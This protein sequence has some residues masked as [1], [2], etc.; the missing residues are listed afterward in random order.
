MRI[1]SAL[2][3]GCNMA[4]KKAL[5]AGNLEA[6]GAARLA[7]LLIKISKGRTVARRLLRLELAGLEGK[8]ALARE[9]RQRMATIRRSGAVLDSQ[10]HRDLL[11]DLEI[12]RRAIVDRIAVEDAAEALDL[13]WQFM[14]LSTPILD[15]C[16]D[17]DETVIGA[18]NADDL[19]AI[20]SAASPD[21]QAVPTGRSRRWRRTPTASTTIS[22]VR[23]R[24][25]WAREAW[26]V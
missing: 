10:K 21:P 13:M 19:G 6:L 11:D 24:R 4:S 7:E 20:A 2:S 22:S 12:H 25:F 17:N 3:P 14:A 26:S 9:L 18:F 8:V 23:W 1:Q 16:Y 15:R 5:N